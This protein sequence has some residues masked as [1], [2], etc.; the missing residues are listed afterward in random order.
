MALVANKS[1]TVANIL[2]ASEDLFL[3][4]SYADVTVDQVAEAANVTK[5][6]VYHH[7]DSKEHL[8]L[9]MLHGDLAEKRHL[10]QQAVDMPGTC[11]ERLRRLTEDFLALPENK[12]NLI[13]LVRR[14][15]NVFASDVRDKLVLAYQ[16]ALPALVERIV[17]DGIRDRELVPSD[18][19][20]LAWHFVALVEVVLTPYAEK[21]FGCDEDKLN[22]VLSLFLGGCSRLDGEG[23][24]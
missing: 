15:V 4:R 13:A 9:A 20:L 22:H 17:R 16:Q 19:R 10:H 6:A 11:E 2:A 18:P 5:G 7:F 8:Y 12:R 23:R 24:P 14:D 3:S 1:Q 21:R